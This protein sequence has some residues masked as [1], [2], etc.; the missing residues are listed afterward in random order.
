MQAK[1]E[2]KKER[3]VKRRKHKQRDM[4]DTLYSG[5]SDESP[6]LTSKH[7]KQASPCSVSP[8]PRQEKDDRP[9]RDL[10]KTSESWMHEAEAR[11]CIDD[12]KEDKENPVTCEIASANGQKFFR[13]P[14][15]HSRKRD[16]RR[17]WHESP[18]HEKGYRSP[19]QVRRREG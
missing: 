5:T 8:N 18:S 15:R 19:R 4:S 6:V 9:N 10:R 2:A 7:R 16:Q 11:A 12:E 14:Y 1:L 3:K 17:S 13:S